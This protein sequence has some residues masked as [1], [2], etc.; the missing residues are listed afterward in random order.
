MCPTQ[1]LTPAF[2]FQQL[3]LEIYRCL[4][5]ASQTLRWSWVLASE[6]ARA[7]FS[8]L[9]QSD[10]VAV[11]LVT[12]DADEITVASGADC[13]KAARCK[14]SLISMFSQ[15]NVFL[16]ELGL[17]LLTGWELLRCVTLRIAFICPIPDMW[18]S[19]D[20]W[21][22]WLRMPCA[23]KQRKAVGIQ[24]KSNT[25]MLICFRYQACYRNV[26]SPVLLLIAK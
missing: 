19:I 1:A 23:L 8:C 6:C 15:L 4:T 18:R 17:F 10:L 5:S 16:H 13:S 21:H 22:V 3:F 20:C 25:P 14:R 24:F 2:V 7:G 12:I 11:I 26:K 9:Y